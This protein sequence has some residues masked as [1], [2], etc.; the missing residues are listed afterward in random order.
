M[1]LMFSQDALAKHMELL[2]MGARAGVGVLVPI[3]CTVKYDVCAI[4]CSAQL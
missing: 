3:V 1:P 2:V 4:A